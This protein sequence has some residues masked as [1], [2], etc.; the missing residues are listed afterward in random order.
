[1]VERDVPRDGDGK[2]VSAFEENAGK[3]G[4]G[5]CQPERGRW[6]QRR[7]VDGVSSVGEEE[8]GVVLD[9]IISLPVAVC[10]LVDS[11]SLARQRVD[12]FAGVVGEGRW[13]IGG[14]IWDLDTPW[15]RLGEESR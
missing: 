8:K 11:F 10:S 13:C 7:V 14:I 12:G 5:R 3:E 6:K 15:A 2:A 4:G 9:G 1:M